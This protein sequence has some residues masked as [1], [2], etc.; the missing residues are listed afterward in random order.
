LFAHPEWGF[1]FDTDFEQAVAT[2]RRIFEELAENK[3]L[4][5]AYHLPWPGLGYV[6]QKAK[7]FE[8][9]TDANQ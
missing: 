3:M 4:A 6:K 1:S 8:W 2:R 9:V 5:L 7:G